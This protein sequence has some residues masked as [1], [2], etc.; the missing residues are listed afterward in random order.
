[1][2]GTPELESLRRTTAELR[3]VI[4]SM[5][6]RYGDIPAVRRLINDVDRIELDTSEFDALSAG[7]THSSARHV[8]PVEVQ[9]IAD[10]PTDPSLWAD[11][12]DEGL[13]GYRR[14]EG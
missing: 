10:G 11:A 7:S 5:R 8:M 14:G 9:M 13:G 1:M 4:T 2:A 12:D 3:F 6:S